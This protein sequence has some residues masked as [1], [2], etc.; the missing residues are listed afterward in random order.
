[1]N[2]EEFYEYMDDQNNYERVVLGIDIA[3]MHV[4]F[5]AVYDASIQCGRAKDVEA[6]QYIINNHINTNMLA[7][8]SGLH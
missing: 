8:I 1:V 5:E 7:K 3:V 2:K 6:M 4:G